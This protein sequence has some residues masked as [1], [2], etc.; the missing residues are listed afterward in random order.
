MTTFTYTIA[1]DERGGSLEFLAEGLAAN[2]DRG[3]PEDG[4]TFDGQRTELYYLPCPRLA[5][6]GYAVPPC[7]YRPLA[8]TFGDGLG[9]FE[10]MMV[11][12][13]D[14]FWKRTVLAGIE[15]DPAEARLDEW[16]EVAR[17]LDE[18]G[19]DEIEY[20]AC[21]VSEDDG[22]LIYHRDPPRMTWAARQEPQ[23]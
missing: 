21:I 17:M 1:D 13:S 6:G 4:T 2:E 10:D 18:E 5:D 7:G 11:S 22:T 16:A 12:N 8:L 3:E 14:A 19:T 20:V 23:P 9:W 15:P